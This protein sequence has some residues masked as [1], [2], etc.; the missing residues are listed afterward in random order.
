VHSDVGLASLTMLQMC[1]LREKAH[2]Q[3]NFMPAGS[4]ETLAPGTYYLTEVD[5]MFRRKYEI[6]A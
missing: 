6:K 1:L 2:L 4:T 5:D 3:K